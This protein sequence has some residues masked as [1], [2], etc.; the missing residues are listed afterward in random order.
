MK[1]RFFT[2]IFLAAGMSFA[3][4]AQETLEHQRPDNLVPN[5]SFETLDKTPCLWIQ[6]ASKIAKS[7]PGWSAPTETHPDIFT[8]TAGPDCWC[9]PNKHSKGTQ[10]ARTG[11]NMVGFKSF[12][13]GG[14]PTY[15][16]EYL[17]VKFKKPL[18]VGERYYVEF[19]VL[20]DITSRRNSN[21][22]G[23]SFQVN[24]TWTGDRLPLYLPVKFKV[25]DLVITDD[26][27]WEKISAV[28]EADQA[29]QFMIIGN[30]CSDPDTRSKKYEEGKN[31]AYYY[32]DDVTVR[33]ADKKMKTTPVPVQCDPPPPL[34]EIEEK[35]TTEDND[36]PTIKYK[37]GQTIELSNVFFETN[38]SELLPESIEE[39]DKLWNILYDYPNMIV[40]IRGHT[41]NVGTD[42]DNI[43]LSDARAKAVADYLIKKKTRKKRITWK[44]YGESK[45]VA[46]NDTEEGRA[47]NRRVE[48]YIVER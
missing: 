43:A 42:E 46:T 12:G 21:N 24:N 2:V 32:L 9:N 31:G 41:D 16:H 30:F 45:P 15:W 40:E 33:P 36:L 44:G 20:R 17:Q 38:K 47:L 10:F 29:Y 23:A 13:L 6:R 7:V 28:I 25:E 11:T 3:A 35:T 22:I 19:W 5:A 4:S 8:T 14:T 1:L 26:N 37:Q 18:T 39:L 48:F 34:V 27:Q